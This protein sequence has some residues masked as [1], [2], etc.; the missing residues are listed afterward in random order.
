MLRIGEVAKRTRLGVE[1]IRYYEKVG[2]IAPPSRGANGYR[3]YTD[4]AVR[5]LLFI[6]RAREL[7][8]S[9][10]D[11][12]SLLELADSPQPNGRKVKAIASRHLDEIG[13]RLADLSRMADALRILTKQC[14]GRVDGPCPF[15]DTL[16]CPAR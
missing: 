2:A 4:D 8:F 9:L 13:K 6:R 16:L 14:P 11:V 12:H 1:T 7:G 3:A 10:K 15:L 5:R